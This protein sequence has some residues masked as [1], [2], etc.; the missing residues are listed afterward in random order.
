VRA[1]DLLQVRESTGSGWRPR[2]GS[3]GGGRWPE[4]ELRLPLQI[5]A[6]PG[7]LAALE[8]AGESPLRLLARHGTGDSVD[9]DAHDR[10][11]SAR[12]VRMGERMPSEYVLRSVEPLWIITEA[13]RSATTLLLP[14]EY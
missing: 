5:A 9:L 14:S 11:A 8:R 12:A 13:D 3:G 7:A 2:A 4:R 10:Q 6:T 1:R